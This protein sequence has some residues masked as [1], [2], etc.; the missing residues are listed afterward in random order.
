[1]NSKIS[2]PAV[3]TWTFLGLAIVVASV[4]AILFVVLGIL[5]IVHTPRHFAWL[6]AFAALAVVN[7]VV[8]AYSLCESRQQGVSPRLKLLQASCIMLVVALFQTV[9]AVR[10]M[11]A[12]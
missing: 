1:M 12:M 6:L 4:P 3:F 7:P 9:L 8:V 5:S 10:V 2:C 11:P